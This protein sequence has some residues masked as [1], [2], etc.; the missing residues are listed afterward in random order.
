MKQ[1]TEQID[2]G[3]RSER[4]GTEQI[5][6][7]SRSVKQATERIEPGSRSVR[8]GAARIESGWRS[9]VFAGGLGLL[10]LASGCRGA[11]TLPAGDASESPS[12]HAADEHAP[13]AGS[14][15]SDTSTEP[16]DAAPRAPGERADVGTS[17]T[18]AARSAVPGV[19]YDDTPF[20][21]G[22]TW[23]VH[24]SRRPVPEIVT[25]PPYRATP[26]PA[27]AIVLFDGHDLSRW[28]SG[29]SD[30]RWT[31]RDGYAEV[32]GT[33]S[34]ET[35]ESFGDCF[36]HLEWA[37]PARVEGESQHRGNSGLFLM[38]RYE[39]QILDSFENRTYAD[40]QAAALYGQVPPRVN[41]CRPP[42]EWQTYDVEFRA[43]RFEGERLVT[44]ATV[45]V[46]HN[47][48]LVQDHVAFLGATRHREVATYAAHAPELPLVLQD[49][50]N[51]VRFREIWVR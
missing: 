3:S 51:P 4:Q 50:G 25:P 28:R 18:D 14:A 6:P 36:V 39:V 20:L 5:E 8:Q 32:N 23:R 33:G 30:G 41:A 16:R 9:V 11:R 38:G 42:G 48:V 40:G 19:G 21:P 37:A 35:K 27:D 22:G 43:P 44:P 24:D 12:G 26:R 34:I 46:V 1:G 13:A 31:V 47:G 15:A 7:G 49:H 29:D 45:T 2:P 17:S 10:G